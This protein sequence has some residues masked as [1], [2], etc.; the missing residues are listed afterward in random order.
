MVQKITP[1]SRAKNTL[2]D[3]SFVTVLPVSQPV[4]TELTEEQQAENKKSV[5]DDLEMFG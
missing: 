3:M 4:K 2:Q 5:L 1:K